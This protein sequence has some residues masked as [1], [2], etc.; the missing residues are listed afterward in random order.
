MHRPLKDLN[1]LVSGIALA[2]AAIIFGQM[3]VHVGGNLGLL[4]FTGIVLP[5]VSHGTLSE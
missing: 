5:F 1:K 3:V 4:P 2:T